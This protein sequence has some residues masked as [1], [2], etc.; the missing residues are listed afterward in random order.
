MSKALKRSIQSAPEVR[1]HRPEIRRPEMR[2]SVVGADV[3]R[4]HPSHQKDNSTRPL[5][6]NPSNRSGTSVRAK[7]PGQR[8]QG[9]KP[10][11]TRAFKIK[12]SSELWFA[13]CLFII[14][15]AKLFVRVSI[16]E[17]S[18]QIENVRNDLLAE[19]AKLRELKVKKAM[20]ANPKQLSVLAYN[21]L[22]MRPTVPQQIRR[23]KTDVE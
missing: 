10:I 8:L 21:K 12:N 18:Y 1:I 2:R 6:V 22:E 4:R 20:L 13:G 17:A 5:K 23:I 11:S 9:S 14:L 7:K 16:I 15:L 19:D 3:A